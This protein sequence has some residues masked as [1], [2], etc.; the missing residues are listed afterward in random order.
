VAGATLPN[1]IIAGVQKA[2][3]SWLHRRLAQHP[4]FFMS[5]PKELAY[6]H[7]PDLI[8]S[9]DAWAEYLS[10]FEGS[11]GHRWRGESTPNYFHSG[12]GPF[13]PAERADTANEMARMLG[14]DLHVIVS[15][16]DP[17]SRAISA[18]WHQFRMGRLDLSESIFRQP[19]HYS[20]I[21]FGLYRRHYEHWS[22]AVGSDR[23]H[24]VLHD[25]LVAD[26]RG[27]LSQVLAT[28]STPE[29]EPDVWSEED[30]A[31][32]VND[33]AWLRQFRQTRNPITS[34]EVAALLE[35][36]ADDISF[37]EEL[38]GRSLDA[39]RD[40]DALIERHAGA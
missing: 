3:T 39:W 31:E 19:D 12:G 6:F 25:D 30:L 5:T 28:I 26:P 23:L 2:G 9:P 37:V 14:D 10:A 11:A 17:V 27:F 40:V 18:Y 20:L 21:D 16:R 13:S 34:I 1:L 35:I 36:F 32:R 15:L 4:D 24:V 7:R 33:P 22:K 8:A 38:L 29:P